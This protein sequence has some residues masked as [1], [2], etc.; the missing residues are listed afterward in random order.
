M[1]KDAQNI[2]NAW[3]KTSHSYAANPQNVETA[4]AEVENSELYLV[5]QDLVVWSKNFNAYKW[6]VCKQAK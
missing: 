5:A 2:K 6:A 3:K 1:H 4:V